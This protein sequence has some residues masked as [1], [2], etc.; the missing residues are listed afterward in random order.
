MRKYRR[1]I[2]AAVVIFLLLSIAL[3]AHALTQRQQ[4][5]AALKCAITHLTGEYPEAEK[6]KHRVLALSSQERL[7]LV[8]LQNGDDLLYCAVHVSDDQTI[9]WHSAQTTPTHETDEPIFY[10]AKSGECYHSKVDCSG[11]KEP[12]AIPVSATPLIDHILRAC[13]R[14]DPVYTP[15]SQAE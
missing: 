11:M 1:W 9:L 15:P 8:N 7:V 13:T 4:N 14:C 10:I 3:T 6:V 2:A 12:L 5:N